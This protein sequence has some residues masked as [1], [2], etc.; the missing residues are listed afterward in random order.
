MF[1]EDK[2]LIE[3]FEQLFASFCCRQ[4][5][6][7]VAVTLKETGQRML[8]GRSGQKA[9]LTSTQPETKRTCDSA[10]SDRTRF[11]ASSLKMMAT[12]VSSFRW[13]KLEVVASSPGDGSMFPST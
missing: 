12:G 10:R 5:P 11:K 1:S 4:S 3:R 7:N 8:I 6:D 2:E 9:R 13:V